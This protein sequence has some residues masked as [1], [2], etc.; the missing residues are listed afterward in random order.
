MKEELRCV[1]TVFALSVLASWLLYK[2]IWGMM[3]MAVLFP[4]YRKNYKKQGIVKRKRLLTIQ[5]ADAMQSMTAAL[6]S[7]FSVEN[8]WKEAEHE[9]C[10]LHGEDAYISREL[11]K[12]NHGVTVNQSVE[13]LLYEFALRSGCEDILE[14]SEVFL[15]AKRSGGNFVKIMQETATRIRTKNGVEQE[16]ATAISGRKMEQKVMNIVPVFLLA[17]LNLTSKDFLEPLYGNV[18][19]VVIMTS[20]LF[21]YLGALLLSQK[22]MDITI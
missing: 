18:L 11:Q 4:I 10:R 21:A 5:F 19:G 2:S 1:V 7:G 6:L 20:A 17:Y 3:V 15:F 14:F 13:K 16:I 22:M 9:M 12:I 8:A